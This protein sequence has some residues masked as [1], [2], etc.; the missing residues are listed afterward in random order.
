MM[1]LL[2]LVCAFPLCIAL[3]L[4]AIPVTF[5]VDM[6]SVIT[7]GSLEPTSAYVEARG[8]FQDTPWS[9]GFVLTNSP[10]NP[11]IFSGTVEVA[12]SAGSTYEYK[13]LY[14]NSA[15]SGDKWEDRG[16]RS[17]TLAATDQVLPLVYFD[18]VATLPTPHNVTFAV[19]VA[20]QIG[21]GTFDPDAG[22]VEARGSFQ[23]PCTWSGGF[24]LTNTADAPNIYTGTYTVSNAPP[25]STVKYKFV[26]NGGTWESI[27]DRTFIMPDSDTNLPLVRFSNELPTGIP[28]TFSVDM[29]AQVLADNFDPTLNYVE[30]R[31]SFQSPS[32][33]TSGFTLTNDPASTSSNIYSGTYEVAQAPGSRFE[34][35]FWS[36]SS[37][38][39]ESPAS[40]GG[41]NRSFTLAS[42]AQVLPTAY[43]ND[44]ATSDLLQEDTEVTFRVN[45]TNAHAIAWST[46]PAFSFD[47]QSHSV[48]LNGNFLNW[49][50]W[51]VASPNEDYK[52]TNAPGSQVYS[53]T[54]VRPKGSPLGLS[55]KFSINGGD[56]EAAQDQNH[57][58]YIRDTGAYTMPLDTFGVQYVEPSSGQLTIKASSPGYVLIQ[59]LGRP[60]IL[61][62]SASSVTGPW[63]DVPGTEGESSKSAAI[64]G[65]Q[66]Y[67][68]LK[69]N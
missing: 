1:K 21:K 23:N 22:L 5:Q 12:G 42:A 11:A 35:K 56:N 27:D 43:F 54:L 52:L 39:W 29:S 69:Q 15:C 9:A 41:G 65:S 60:G 53:I 46:Y 2:P 66:R 62:E 68:R 61:L 25:S 20:V 50:S 26:L 57:Y 16:N 38:S 18:D 55:Y 36:S 8:S 33:W 49:W 45:M 37:L 10:E 47:P 63:A 59:W 30:A 44:L 32:A 31:G 14:Q 4:Q 7:L 34:Y 48:Y 3:N 28:V 58:R 51:S 17:F 67:Y 24:T 19:D 6:T 13:F 40:T 64:E